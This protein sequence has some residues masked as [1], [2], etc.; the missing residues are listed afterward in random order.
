MIWTTDADDLVKSLWATH[1][2][3]QISQELAL[4][5]HKFSR[6]A[7]I[8]RLHRLGVTVDQKAKVHPQTRHDIAFPGS[9]SAAAPRRMPAVPVGSTAFKVIHS[10]KRQ[11]NLPAVRPS[12]AIVCQDASEV[13]PLNVRFND[14]EDCQCRWP[15]GEGAD[16]TFCGHVK[17]GSSSYC[18]PHFKL[19]VGPGTVAERKSN[20]VSARVA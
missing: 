5:G 6:N 8:G 13:L 17:F 11:Q 4:K 2:G 16:M 15:A 9:V 18:G 14:L 1:T 3:T 19:S 12:R 7:V 20:Y 10:I